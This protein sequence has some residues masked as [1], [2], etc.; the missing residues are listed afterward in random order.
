[1]SPVV[2]DASVAAKWFLP[3]PDAPAALRLLDGGH[4]LAAPDLICSEVGNVA[5]KLHAR[6]VLNAGEAS[7]MIEH[8]LSMPLEIHDSVSLLSPAL[9]I[10]IVTNRPIYDSLYLALAVEL[11][12][13]VVT[14]DQRWVN[15]LAGSPFARFLRL[16]SP[17][18]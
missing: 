5:W 7:E 14:A 18:G 16:L 11:G 10:A 15:A 4:P 6:S 1:M 3:E 12:G 9:D 2:V 13:T 17:R 8:F